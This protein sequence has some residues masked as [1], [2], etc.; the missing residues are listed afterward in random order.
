MKPIESEQLARKFLE[1]MFGTSLSKRKLVVGYDSKR[2]PQI[3]EFDLVSDGTDVIGEIKSGRNSKGNYVR[4][5]ANCIFLSKVKARKK[6]LV[7]TDK[8]FYDHFKANSEGVIQK[9]IDIIYVCIEDLLAKPQS[10]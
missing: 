4:T 2:K 8:E 1:K 7:L 6:L 10:I 3:H 9:N 5:L